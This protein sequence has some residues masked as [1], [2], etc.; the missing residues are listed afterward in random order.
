MSSCSS[1]LPPVLLSSPPPPICLLRLPP[2]YLSPACQQWR[3]TTCRRHMQRAL[4]C[5]RHRTMLC[6]LRPT[7]TAVS[8]CAPSGFCIHGKTL[9]GVY[10]PSI[11]SWS[12]A[13]QAS[14]VSSH[15]DGPLARA[16]SHASPFKA[17]VCCSGGSISPAPRTGST[18]A[19]GVPSSSSSSLDGAAYSDHCTHQ[20]ARQSCA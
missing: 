6:R 1:P 8:V 13:P 4:R 12:P 18:D 2:I 17:N 7:T 11:Q 14:P 15:S 10:S 19:A 16:L 20:A 5:M 9:L 3:H